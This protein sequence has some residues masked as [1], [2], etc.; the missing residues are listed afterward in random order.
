L[1]YSIQVMRRGRHITFSVRSRPL[2]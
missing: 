2:I 1:I